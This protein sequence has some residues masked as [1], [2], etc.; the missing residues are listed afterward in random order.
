[1]C[2]CSLPLTVH[3]PPSLS[4]A[5]HKAGRRG[6]EGL[7]N[8]RHMPVQMMSALHAEPDAELWD[9][10][11]GVCARALTPQ[12]WCEEMLPSGWAWLTNIVKY[13]W[14]LG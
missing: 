1:M 4:A 5:F 6:G 9:D 3:R 12:L 10:D 7:A 11:E 8:T 13:G 14:F 2:W